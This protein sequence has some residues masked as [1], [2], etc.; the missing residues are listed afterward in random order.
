MSVKNIRGRVRVRV[1][2]IQPLMLIKKH[3]MRNLTLTPTLTT[4]KTLTCVPSNTSYERNKNSNLNPNPNPNAYLISK[5]DSHAN[6]DIKPNFNPRT[7]KKRFVRL[8]WK[9]E[10]AFKLSGTC[11]DYGKGWGEWERVREE[12]RIKINGNEIIMDGVRDEG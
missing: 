6:P 3:S 7:S 10:P 2:N 5:T 8:T 4:T 12:E 11:Y 9:V 1:E